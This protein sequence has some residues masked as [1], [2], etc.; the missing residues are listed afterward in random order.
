[1]TTGAGFSLL[2][3]Y[4]VSLRFVPIYLWEHGDD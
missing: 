4:R 2:C 1:M 3:A